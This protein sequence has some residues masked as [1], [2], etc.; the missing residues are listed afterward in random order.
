MLALME[1]ARTSSY[2]TKAPTETAAT[3]ATPTPTT[4]SSS[5]DASS[6][7]DTKQATAKK[8]DVSKLKWFRPSTRR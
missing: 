6:S 7:D 5:D 4:T 3:A 1:A 2:D 8:P